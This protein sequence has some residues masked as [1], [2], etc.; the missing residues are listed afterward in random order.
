MQPSSHS[1]NRATARRM[2][3]PRSTHTPM[4]RALSVAFVVAFGAGAPFAWAAPQGGQVVAGAASISQSGPLTTIQQ[5]SQ[6]A[7]VNWQ[8][9]G[10]NPNETV[11]FQQPGLNAAILN[12]VV[13]NLPTNINGLLQGNGK[14]F[15]VNPNGIVVG[16]N[17]IVNV[18]GGFVAS[19]QNID[20][21]AFM[22][23]GALLLTGGKDGSIQI[24]GTVSTPGGDVTIIAPKV[25]VGTG[26]Q[27]SAG[28]AVQL[29]A[30]SS[31]TLSNGQFTVIP[32]GSDAGQLTVQGVING[33]KTQLAAVNDN[34]GALAI[35]TSG[36]IRATGTQSNPDGT[37]SIVAQGTGGNVQLGGTLTA[38][39]AIG[40]GGKIG[41]QGVNVTVNA[42]S[43]DVSGT[44]GGEVSLI[45][46]AAAGTTLVTDSAI[47]ARGEAGS[48]GLVRITGR[49]TGLM[50]TTSVDASGS[51]GGGTILVGGGFHGADDRIANATAT[52]VGSGVVL[53]ANGTQGDATAGE[54][55]VWS[56]DTTRFAG[57][58][59]ATGS[60]AGNGGQAE[61]SGAGTLDYRGFADL[62][63]GAFGTL[64]LDPTDVTIQT[65]GPDSGATWSGGTANFSSS[66]G[67][68]VITV[69]TLQ[70]QLS[71]ASVTIDS[72]AGT[73][74]N[75]DITVNNAIVIPNGRSLIL[76]AARDI[77][78]N[79]D[80][81]T[82][83]T[84][85][86]SAFAA[87]AFR[88]IN[89]NTANI[90]G[91]GGLSNVVLMS[92]Q[93]SAPTTATPTI[94]FG[95]NATGAGQVNFNYAGGTNLNA[96][97]NT[98]VVTGCSTACSLNANDTALTAA[99]TSTYLSSAPDVS[100]NGGA[101]AGVVNVGGGGTM[102]FGGFRDINVN[103]AIG[104]N[105]FQATNYGGVVGG[106]DTNLPLD[107]VGLYALRDVSIN[108]PIT[109]GGNRQSVQLKSE[110]DIN[111]NA[112][113]TNTYTFAANAARDINVTAALLETGVGYTAG[114]VLPAGLGLYAGQRATTLAD[115][116]L[117]K[118]SGVSTVVDGYGGYS[119]NIGAVH[120]NRTASPTLLKSD[121]ELDVISG[122]TATA[123]CLPS[124]RADFLP[125]NVLLESSAGRTGP[126]AGSIYIGGF[127]NM[128]PERWDPVTGAIASSISASGDISF[129]AF[130]NLTLN[131]TALTAGSSIQLLAAGGNWGD[132]IP[133]SGATLADYAGIVYF[134]QPNILLSATGN[135]D[136]RS[137]TDGT[138][139]SIGASGGTLPGG[140]AYSAART[141]QARPYF[142]D[143][144]NPN[145]I[146]IR[147]GSSA[148][149]LSGALTIQGFLNTVLTLQNNDGSAATSLTTNGIAINSYGDVV[150]PQHYIRAL[151]GGSATIAAGG[152]NGFVGQVGSTGSGLVGQVKLT[153]PNPVVQAGFLLNLQSGYDSTGHHLDLAGGTGS[154]TSGYGIGGPILLQYDPAWTNWVILDIGGF[155]SAP[156]YAFSGS[157]TP[158]LG[159]FDPNVAFSVGTYGQYW[160]N[161]SAFG[162]VTME[163]NKIVGQ[164]GDISGSNW[165]FNDTNL[166]IYAGRGGAL[167]S[168]GV[169]TF[170]QPT[171]ISGG[172]S[173]LVLSSNAAGLSTL[174]DVDLT[175]VTF[176]PI[177]VT[178]GVALKAQIDGTVTTLGVPVTAPM[179][180]LSLL[181]FRNVDLKTTG[182]PISTANLSITPNGSSKQGDITINSDVYVSNAVTLTGSSINTTGNNVISS[183]APAGSSYLPSFTA[184]GL[185]TAWGGTAKNSTI[186]TSSKNN[187]AN[188]GMT[189]RN[190]AA[191]T[192]MTINDRDSVIVGNFGATTD[193]GNIVINAQGDIGVNGDIVRTGTTNPASITLNADANLSSIFTGYDAYNQGAVST[194][195]A[196][197]NAAGGDGTGVT[198]FLAPVE[199]VVPI[200]TE[201]G[202]LS[203]QSTNRFGA[204]Y[205][206]PTDPGWNAAHT[207]YTISSS[208]PSSLL[209]YF[210]VGTV[211]TPGQ[212][213]L[214]NA[215][216][217]YSQAFVKGVTNGGSQVY[218]ITG[219]T[220]STAA[221]GQ[222]TSLG[223]STNALSSTVNNGGSGGTVTTTLNRTSFGVAGDNPV[224][225]A[226]VTPTG[227]P[228][229]GTY[230]L[231][232]GQ[233]FYV[234]AGGN[235]VYPDSSWDVR[236]TGPVTVQTQLG[237]IVIKSGST[238]A[239][240]YQGF[241]ASG[242]TADVRLSSNVPTAGQGL[243][244]PENLQQN[245]VTKTVNGNVLIGGYR[246]IIALD[247]VSVQ[248][249]GT[250]TISLIAGRD[251]L[252]EDN[253]GVAN[254]GTL[255]L[256]AGNMIEQTTGK[257]ISANNLVLLTGRGSNNL[258]TS[259][260]NLAGYLQT[261]SA[262]Y[263]GAL[264]GGTP[265]TG[266][267]EVT[268]NKTLNVVSTIPA[269]SVAGNVTFT[270]D[271]PVFD[272][273]TPL[274]PKGLT[275]S[276]LGGSISGSIELTT[277][278]GD[279]NVNAPIT[280]TNTGGEINIKSNAGN[281]A[282]N[283]NVTTTG[284]AFVQAGKA[285]SDS[286]GTG[287]L[288]AS[289]AVLTG[290]TTIG[291]AS[292]AVK[293][294]VSTLALVSGANAY[295]NN[296]GSLT[297]AGQTSNN[298]SLSVTATGGT[299]TV[300][301][302][303]LQPTILNNAPGANLTGTN[304][305]GSG[306]VTLAATG[307][308]SDVVFDAT[309]R[310]G[311]GTV[312]VT[313][314]RNVVEGQP[315]LVPGTETSASTNLAVATG[316][317][318]VL[319][320]G[321]TIGGD[322]AATLDPLDVWSGSGLISATAAGNH[323]ASGVYLDVLDTTGNVT[324]DGSGVNVT[325]GK[326]VDVTS[327]ASTT[328]NSGN[329][330]VSGAV[331]AQNAGYV[332]LAA[333]RN[334]T[335]GGAVSTTG[336]GNVVLTSGLTGTGSVTQTAA[337]ALSTGT[338]EINVN[339]ANG[340]T[341]G[342][343]A[344]TAGNIVTHAGT[345]IAQTGGKLTGAGVAL[346]AG[347]M[348]GASGSAVQTVASTLVT[349][350]AGDQY[351]SNAGN[352]T[353]A[354][355]TTNNGAINVTNAGALTVG[356]ASVLTGI[357][358]PGLTGGVTA[359][360]PGLSETA[361]S[362]NGS[363]AVNLTATSAT[364]DIVT[365][366]TVT[367]GTGNIT[368][369]AA[370]NVTDAVAG[371]VSTGGTGT[372]GVTATVGNITM[373]NGASYATAGGNI[374]ATAA[375]NI[376]LAQ[377]TTGS[378]KAGT[379]TLT[380]TNG[381][382]SNSRAAGANNVTA[383]T[384]HAIAATG[385]G[386][387][388]LDGATALTTDISTLGA[389]VTGTGDAVIDNTNAAMLTLG[390]S[391]LT[392]S[393]A[394]GSVRV[395]TAGAVTT[396]NS[397]NASNTAQ[398]ITGDTGGKLA[399]NVGTVTLANNVTAGTLDINSG[400]LVQQT[401]GM[402][403]SGT[404]LIDATRY[405]SG[406]DAT[407]AN[408]S[409]AMTENG[410]SVSG[411]YTITT[412][413]T[414][415]QTGS[416]TV[417]SNL[418]ESGF[419][420]G[421][422]SGT[423]TV[424]GNY[425]GVNAFSGS[426]SVTTGGSNTT[427][428]ANAATTG[429]VQAIGAGP[430]FDLSSANLGTGRDITVDLRGQTATVTGNTPA[431][432]LNGATGGSNSL[433]TVTVKTSAPVTV[434]TTTQDYN[435]V[436]SAAID[437]G[438]HT[439]TV[440]A[441][442]G[443]A[444]S[445]SLQATP[446]TIQVPGTKNSLNYNAANNT[447]NGGQGS[448]IVLNNSG[449][450]IGGLSIANAESANVATTGDVTLGSVKL[451]DGLSVT[452]GGAIAQMANKSVA[453]RTLDLT[454]VS[455]IGTSAAPVSFDTT[456]ALAAGATPVLATHDGAGS[457]T[458]ATTGAVQLG[459][460]VYR[461]S[462]TAAATAG[463]L[464]AQANATTGGDLT[465]LAAG[466]VRTGAT[467][468]AGA[469]GN[470]DIDTSAGSITL[471]NAVTAGGSGL[472][473]LAAATDLN[474]GAAVSSTSGEVNARA[475][476]GD[477]ALGAN[478]STSG[479]VFVQASDAIT[480]SSGTLS[481]D[482]AVLTAGKTIG[483]AAAP[484]R[485]DVNTLAL[486][487]SGNASAVNDKA[488]TLAAQTSTNGSV[489][490]ATTKGALTVSSVSLSPGITD[491][492]VGASVVG[493]SANGSGAVTLAASGSGADVVLD[494][495]V[496]SGT[497]TVAATAAHDIVLSNAAQAATGT[498]V[499]LKAGNDIV[500][501]TSNAT[502][503]IKATT[504]MLTA[505]GDIGS[506]VIDN[507]ITGT[508]NAAALQ[509]D[510]TNLQVAA[511]GSATLRNEGA[512]VIGTSSAGGY[513]GLNGG[514]P[515][516]QA[517]GATLTAGAVEF[518][519]TRDT[520]VGQVAL[521]N[522]GD[523]TIAGANYAG[524]DYS[525]ASQAGN[526]SLTGTL[527]VNGNVALTS[528]PG[529]TV[530][531]PPSNLASAGT[532]VQNGVT[533]NVNGSQQPL[534]VVDA[535]THT[536]VVNAQGAGA[537]FVLTP[538]IV[539]QLKAAGV[540]TVTVD[541][542]NTTTS[543]SVASLTGAAI[544]V[545]NANNAVSGG[546][547]VRT[548]S[549]A[550]T[551]PTRT[552]RNYN[553]TD[554]AG[555][556]DLSGTALIVNAARGT[557]YAPGTVAST[558]TATANAANATAG[559][560]TAQGSNVTLT[561]TSVGS[562]DVRDAYDV[563]VNSP[564]TLNVN[565]VHA[566]HD[567]SLVAGAASSGNL[568]V[569]GNVTAGG[570]LIGVGGRDVTIASGATVSAAGPVTLV[571]DETAGASAGSGWFINNGRI[572]SD[573][574]QV[575]VYGVAGDTPAGYTPVANQMVLGD[576][577]GFSGPVP[578][579]NWGTNY[580]ATA[581]G[582]LYQAGTGKLN[583]VQ[584]WY[585]RTLV[586]LPTTQAVPATVAVPTVATMPTSLPMYVDPD[587]PLILSAGF[588][589]NGGCGIGQYAG[590]GRLGRTGGVEYDIG[591]PTY[592]NTATRQ[593]GEVRGARAGDGHAPTF[594]CIGERAFEGVQTGP[595]PIVATHFS[596]NEDVLF[597]FDRSS[598]RDMLP[599]G[600]EALD[601]I[602][603]NL[604]SEYR[605]L[606]VVSIIGHTDR[607]GPDAYNHELSLARAQTV[608]DYM[609]KHG[610]PV[611]PV[612]VAGVG[613]AEPVTKDCPAGRTP[614]SIRCLQPDR[615]VTIDVL[616]EQ[617]QPAA[618]PTTSPAK[619]PRRIDATAPDYGVSVVSSR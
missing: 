225:D 510:V 210:S 487:S 161:I 138:G 244:H 122:C 103:G 479:N 169:L 306:A 240:T 7:I 505:G 223:F 517:A 92:G 565:Y 89:V 336:A 88:D 258:Q 326:N 70:S 248:P 564:T 333:D 64:L 592:M 69:A 594:D 198:F 616:G 419:T 98:I 322:G 472:V 43:L 111:L 50:G 36:T 568:N 560:N 599:G 577:D 130:G 243:G 105:A 507:G 230:A 493:V 617:R 498:A 541:L 177:G 569:N 538:T 132:P 68:S 491:N 82:S 591:V 220:T 389:I 212:T 376:A 522:G 62:S 108:A 513:F 469:N 311:T 261:P 457:T 328:A 280:T 550:L 342:A 379:V 581:N 523:L 37:I 287:T 458:V 618:R 257:T 619:A 241:H 16:A 191:G 86:L 77:N 533:T 408:G 415:N 308:T 282:L 59:H 363:G 448:R 14:V 183:L 338:G 195:V 582:P 256:G 351:L 34:L 32:T 409:G 162:N 140:G 304:A 611:S 386:S 319:N 35:N 609:V 325:S 508:T 607:I 335:V 55:V 497:G 300:G 598:E 276:T 95:T 470:I 222:F 562:L 359:V 608:R 167:D 118:A 559:F 200:Y 462:D 253:I 446:G 91:T 354:A 295:V 403:S 506:G 437:I 54:V 38:A 267:L 539:S 337:G 480:Q 529:G 530:T 260:N 29:V 361:V 445:A 356:S 250:G 372:I 249:T 179:N 401:G 87:Y 148:N 580:D 324:L 303:N 291:A 135:V 196:Q 460:N 557:D 115:Y 163:N 545:A 397:L 439:L 606:R 23:G 72:H 292:S 492:A 143:V 521:Q 504:A 378:D 352:A 548:G 238:Y 540:T 160:S 369:T 478:L 593:F 139:T 388:A 147:Y 461:V 422:V 452:S 488:L 402:L 567:V 418:T 13:G 391:S 344:T 407:L 24:L 51:G 396:A 431:I 353:L 360:A 151:N 171:T 459:G 201:V 345:A 110:R 44:Q 485:T 131:E 285:I 465:M 604:R 286:A 144:N 347:T 429:I 155:K 334:L 571:A 107:T 246:D 60:G 112:N 142:N 31:V 555:P 277:T 563:A 309:A 121:A 231:G 519:T 426:G 188:A 544:T 48:G 542:G 217:P 264:A 473:R 219:Y 214:S 165:G 528:G 375:G 468:T 126:I 449:N 503:Q 124:E 614:D 93:T 30:A 233:Q 435:L 96:T 164:G 208:S 525:A 172:F 596:L 283:S 94:T 272:S 612:T 362:A 109:T 41:V 150:I 411:N 152:A 406:S 265:Y 11:R 134:T 67:T 583:G 526:V 159:S 499:V 367:S 400:G 6:R 373:A 549:P 22:Q 455:G 269:N 534:V 263:T 314:G 384:L 216:S 575:A 441:V 440:N 26:A 176:G 601:A 610:L 33:A 432:L 454:A 136:I 206:V 194:A 321:N 255:T 99:N 383:G 133:V 234:A 365:N 215:I 271:G 3:R 310:S 536:A 74:G 52:T 312:S 75:G 579:G 527:N 10:I 332:R 433:G 45:G 385:I 239:D 329:L 127:H 207:Q 323:P 117:G 317:N 531:A 65:A 106:S 413:G 297:A 125:A 518:D 47:A 355:Q 438:T 254:T 551:S 450:T 85:S 184:T 90:G 2:Y 318:I 80:V 405:T 476:A 573:A 56:N 516:A 209:A 186:N 1:K 273:T 84:G 442:A 305:N 377:A 28:S 19:T 156:I 252:L 600:R 146:V 501:S 404:T 368:L 475:Y 425:S 178:R 274:Q 605:S 5:Q 236:V 221:Q 394:K 61:V 190:V 298:G 315:A 393:A 203:L 211:V 288:T 83:S 279:I 181:G 471:S 428:N 447:L 366:A 343:A 57:T 416:T 275:T 515:I 229:A 224:V 547:T 182:A 123:V 213:V 496:T 395:A 486:V 483:A 218:V 434:K 175:N 8:S 339:A 185:A 270:T 204:D 12:R 414:L 81:T 436:Q 259:V 574:G 464:L 535:T 153:D 237:N 71:A 520:S 187:N 467:V 296:A 556:I 348:I 278:A 113:V 202:V 412:A 281:V 586:A 514:G 602:I 424:G 494:Q 490:V 603:A 192:T 137:G 481:G 76:N 590:S 374:N 380:A 552:V 120:F 205:V 474:I 482:G 294:A 79:A 587:G 100:I 66:G 39:A 463:T 173:N 15:L 584:V 421:T 189:V 9:F 546:W 102:Y 595:G 444:S 558:I 543:Y 387:G 453:A 232:L 489:N 101:G 578:V 289:G 242:D 597:A 168:G 227:D 299:L 49:N 226:S 4:L 589:M 293:T 174:S 97:V 262:A 484:I 346:D 114:W 572:H 268:N 466:P 382:I 477:V 251:L 512:T 566:N 145:H 417:G 340:I 420:G 78:L 302:V 423:V 358:G 25:E 228:V 532:V 128:T 537:D 399:N 427:I 398:L 561:Q 180:G 199:R 390:S 307:S 73:G 235:A 500:N 349:R 576:I 245:L 42:A 392:N 456:A 554:S 341:F 553:L 301:S 158:T 53:S 443:S 320:A 327:I 21:A 119:N 331:A 58:I 104:G 313:A 371:S 511:G 290:G 357:T 613:N 451:N 170:A 18:Q 350:S 247:A 585:K 157:A 316:G 588:T 149:A 524:G 502:D 430:N 364:G 570:A 46:D 266:T 410:S 370:R 116:N 509:L 27:L 193:Q 141:N 40:T 284:S 495:N 615:R 330:T 20:D 197:G 154:L 63:G 166:Q 381:A 17:G 129:N